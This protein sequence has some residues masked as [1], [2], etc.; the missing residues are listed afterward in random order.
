MQVV[1]VMDSQNCLSFVPHMSRL[2]SKC[3][4]LFVMKLDFVLI[5]VQYDFLPESILIKASLDNG[6]RSNIIRD[7]MGIV[8]YFFNVPIK[9]L[10]TAKSY[11][12]VICFP[13]LSGP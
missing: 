13:F 12:S 6:K 2:V 5:M 11:S 7:E 1:N 4:K 10:H 8:I 9:M 3:F